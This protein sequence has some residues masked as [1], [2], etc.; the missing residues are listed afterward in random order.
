MQ[1][2]NKR[3]KLI[4]KKINDVDN[5]KV[6]NVRSLDNRPNNIGRKLA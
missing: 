4:K 6:S 5:S 3:R 2:I 1:I